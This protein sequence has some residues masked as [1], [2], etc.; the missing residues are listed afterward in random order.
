MGPGLFL[1]LALRAF[2]ARAETPVG[3]EAQGVNPLS[4]VDNRLGLAVRDER[5]RPVSGRLV[6]EQLKSASAARTASNSFS[7]RLPRARFILPSLELAAGVEIWMA[8]LA[9]ALPSPRAVACLPPPRPKISAVLPV[10]LGAVLARGVSCLPPRL[11]QAPLSSCRCCL[12][13]L[14]C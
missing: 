8:Q 6:L 13:V 2:G 11:Q 4:A 9:Q 1:V 12:E 7:S 10:L 3:L 14:R 5:G